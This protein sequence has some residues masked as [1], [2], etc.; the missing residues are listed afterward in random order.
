MRILRICPD[1]PY[2]PNDGVRMDPFYTTMHLARRGHE[3]TLLAFQSDERDISPMRQYCEL[4]TIP[5]HGR[6]SLPNVARGLREGVPVNYVK[7]RDARMAGACQELLQIG[8]Y[9]AVV[10]D[11]SSLGWYVFQIRQH[12]QI[13][14][15]TRWHNV[16]TLIWQRWAECQKNPVTRALG[17][18]QH[19][20]VKRFEQKLA[21]CSDVCLTVGTR[22]TELLQE[23]AP[24]ARVRLLPAGVDVGRYGAAQPGPEAANILFLASGYKW[25]A[26]VDA[27]ERLHEEIMPLVWQRVPEARLYITGRDTTA[28]MQGWA[29]S[30]RVVLTGFVPDEREV[31]ARSGVVVVPMMLGGGI[32]LKILTALAAGRAVVSTSIGAEGVRGLQDGEHLLIRDNPRVFADAIVDVLKDGELRHHLESSGRSF[33]CRHYDWHV[34]AEQWEEVLASLEQRAMARPSLL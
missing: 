11:Y 7:Y 27:V 24:G 32:K 19:R 2:P 28:R 34:L 25:H 26:N 22:D 16:D 20:L 23:L 13:P 6:N 12:F 10:V 18:W 5:F 8:K 15:I 4:H 33:V 30:G 21:L 17:G 1:V 14:V 3:I 9:D 29:R 31:I